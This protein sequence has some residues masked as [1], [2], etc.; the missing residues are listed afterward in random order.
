MQWNYAKLVIL[1]QKSEEKTFENCDYS[2]NLLNSS[3]KF[4]RFV[5]FNL[6]PQY[7]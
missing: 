2:S 3:K 5:K 4:I 1:F 7:Q 6:P